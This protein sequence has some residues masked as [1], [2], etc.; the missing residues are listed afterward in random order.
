M[1]SPMIPPDQ[2]SS[3]DAPFIKSVIKY[4]QDIRVTNRHSH[5]RGQ[6][7]G[8]SQGLISVDAGGARW[9]VPATHGVWIPPDV[10]HSLLGSHG[11]FTGWSVYVAQ[12]LCDDLQM[13][14]CI[15][16]LS[17]LLRAAVARS[18]LWK[19]NILDPSQIRLAYVILDEIR[20]MRQVSLGLPM[21]E[22]TRIVKVAMALSESPGDRRSMEAWAEWAGV[23][24]RTLRRHFVSETGFTFSEWRQRVRVLRS[25]EMLAAG[26]SI[27][28]ISLDLGYESLSAFIALFRRHIGTTP[29]NYRKRIT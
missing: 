21:P 9:V 6:L 4:S 17:E 2:A 11:P 27:T 13:R 25:L 20:S 14:P 19:N 5:L 16:E 18:I 3:A 24:L 23:S 22:D 1:T 10:P 7:L 28:E 8:A 15:L 29:A 12:S 26:R